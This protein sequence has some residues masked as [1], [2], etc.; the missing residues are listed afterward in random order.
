MI[1]R[2][3]ALS[4]ALFLAACGLQE[5]RPTSPRITPEQAR[6]R[7][8]SA[9][10]KSVGDR[11][12]WA[13]DIYAAF[14]ALGLDASA[15][16]TC[17]VVAITEQESG[18]N[19][20]PTVPNLPAIAWKEI[21]RQREK[22]GIPELV[23]DAALALPSSD[24]RSYRS[25]IDAVKTEHDLSSVYEDLIDRVP[26]GRRLLADRNPV[27]TGG[28]MQV[29]I[30]FANEHARS[31]SYPYPVAKTLREE[32]FTRRGGMYFGIAHLLDY[33]APYGE[34]IYRFADY[35][36]GHY[37]SRN[38]ALQKALATL[39]GVP[40]DLDGDLIPHD[41]RDV[42]AT[43]RAARLLAPR[44]ELSN[45][46]VRHDLELE[47]K[48]GLEGT[49][50][51]ARV[52]RMADDSGKPVPRAVLPQIKLSSPKITRALTTEWFARRVLERQKACLKRI[53]A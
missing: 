10:P 40:L 44:L 31:R 15:E 26:L 47:N 23:L 22:L 48:P 39:A 19:A 45:E 51:Y 42:G 25:R 18:F 17:A 33:P 49:K 36:A 43:E 12:G 37:A 32:V 9:L 34:M 20:D 2:A 8:A 24:G 46:Q 28:P 52:M 7:I 4:I 13:A 1:A 27:R 30:A 11:N 41:G 35:N 14:A 50:L 21:A 6:A 38:A 53:E 29:S 3:L 16:N 5:P